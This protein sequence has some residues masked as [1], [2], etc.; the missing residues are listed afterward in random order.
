MN[1]TNE[2]EHKP[3]CLCF[4]RLLFSNLNI[5]GSKIWIYITIFLSDGEL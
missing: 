2:G 1:E 5:G 4:P 3:C